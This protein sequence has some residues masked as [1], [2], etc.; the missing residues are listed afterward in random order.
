L[1]PVPCT[2]EQKILKLYNY[3]F[4][5]K[6]GANPY[7]P[8]AQS[9]RR[10]KKVR[11]SWNA[12]CGWAV[13]TA[14]EVSDAAVTAQNRATGT[15][16][17]LLVGETTMHEEGPA[18]SD[19]PVTSGAACLG[20]ESQAPRGETRGGIFRPPARHSPRTEYA[21]GLSTGLATSCP[22][23]KCPTSPPLWNVM[24]ERI[25]LRSLVDSLVQSVALPA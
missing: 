22:R 11:V 15:T 12:P 3:R 20:C 17:R 7:R 14:A 24:A 9:D 10:S 19:G 23:T 18:D 2:S 13:G 25:S 1:P 21:F 8:N 16:P 5:G 4:A 6:V